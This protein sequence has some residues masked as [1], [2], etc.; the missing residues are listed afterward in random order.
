MNKLDVLKSAEIDKEKACAAFYYLQKELTDEISIRFMDL[1]LEKYTY[2]VF[3]IRDGH[4][5][6]LEFIE[7]EGNKYNNRAELRFIFSLDE[8]MSKKKRLAYE[9]DRETKAKESFGHF[10][11]IYNDYIAIPLWIYEEYYF[12]IDRYYDVKYLPNFN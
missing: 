8:K 3:I 11:P 4:R 10:K 6:K 12:S 7:G 5:Y 2:P 9:S 1:A